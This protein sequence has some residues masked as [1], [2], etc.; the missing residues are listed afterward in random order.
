M[1]NHSFNVLF[2]RFILLVALVCLAGVEP[3]L[4]Q[5]SIIPSLVIHDPELQ[6]FNT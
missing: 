5:R 2:S 3:V 4:A 1:L 6:D